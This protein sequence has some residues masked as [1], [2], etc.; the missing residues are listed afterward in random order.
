TTSSVS[1][2]AA[3]KYW[4]KL[5]DSLHCT[6]NSDTTNLKIDSLN[7]K[8]SLGADTTLCRN[9]LI[10]LKTPANGW[11]RLSFH[12]STGST[13]SIA[14]VTASG[15]YSVTVSDTTVCTASASKNINVLGS[16]APTV[17]FSGDTIC[18][19]QNY[20]PV[21]LTAPTD[22]VASYYW[23]F[24]DGGSSSATNAAHFYQNS[25]VYSASLRVITLA[26]CTTTVNKYV[27]VDALPTASFNGGA[28]CVDNSY[29][30]N[31]LSSPSSGSSLI[32]WNWDFGDGGLATTQNPQYTYATSGSYTAGLMVTDNYGCSG[33]TSHSITLTGPQVF[34]PVSLT[35][36]ANWETFGTNGVLFAWNP[37][38]GATSYTLQIATNPQFTNAQ[39]YPG[40]TICRDSVG[41]FAGNTQYYWRIVAYSTCG[42]SSSSTTGTFRTFKPSDIGSGCLA[43]WLA[44]DNVTLSGSTTNVST[45]L[46]TSGNAYHATATPG[47]PTWASEPQLNG[48]HVLHFSGT[49]QALKGPQIPGI[50][51]KSFSIFMVDKGDNVT[52]SPAYGQGLFTINTLNAGMWLYRR[53]YYADLT[54][55]NNYSSIPST[56][57]QW[58]NINGFANTGYPY[59]LMGLRKDFGNWAQLDTNGVVGAY[60]DN[61]SGLNSILLGAFTNGPYYIGYAS[62]FNQYFQGSI[63]ETIVYTCVLD[64]D[65]ANNVNNYLYTKYAPPVYLGPDTTETG[66]VCPVVLNAG[67]R[68][69]SYLWSTGATTQTISVQQNGTYWVRVKDVFNRES[70]DTINVTLP[71]LGSTPGDTAICYG[72]QVQIS[73]LFRGG[74]SYNYLWSNGATTSSIT[75][76]AAG[77]Y[78]CTVSN[79]GNASC[80]ILSDIVHVHVDSFALTNLLTT[81]TLL[82]TG[83]AVHLANTT[84]P[85]VSY[86]WSPSGDTSAAPLIYADGQYSL[87]VVDANGC[88]NTDT[89]NVTTHSHAPITD[90]SASGICLGNATAFTSLAAVPQPDAIDSFHWAFDGAIPATASTANPVVNFS[91]YGLHQVSLFVQTDSGCTGTITKIDTIYPTP[92]AGFAYSGSN[93]APSAAGVLCAGDNTFGI[94]SDSSLAIVAIDSI[95]SRVWE[96]DGVVVDSSNSSTII[97]Q[98][99]NPGNYTVSLIVTN[100]EGCTDSVSRPVRVFAPLNAD[101][102][103]QNVCYGQT[104]KFTDLTASY[105]LVS[106]SWTFGDNFTSTTQN[107]THRYTQPLSF[108]ATLTVQNAIGC[109]ANITK[110]V[111]IYKNPVAAFTDTIACVGDA[112]TPVDL[113]QTFGDPIQYWSW[114]IA[115]HTYTTQAP[116]YTFTDTGTY[117]IRL[118]ITT[119]NSCADSTSKHV[120]VAPIPV[121][122][123]TYS[124]LY[125]SA[126]LTITLTNNSTGANWYLWDFGD[127]STDSFNVN[128][129]Y[130]YQNNGDYTIVLYA[131][132]SYG[133]TDSFSRK[134]SVIATNLDL[135]V[136]RVWTYQTPQPNG[137]IFF[138]VVAQISNVQTRPITSAQLKATVGSSGVMIQD[139]TG[140]LLPGQTIIDTFPAQFDVAP[141]NANSYVCVEGFN[142]NNGETET[143][144]DNNQACASL[145]SSM[146]L[147]GPAPMPAV[148]QSTL[149]II[150]PAAG[151]VNIDIIDQLGQ[152][153]VNNESFT[154]PAGRS[155][156]E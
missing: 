81:D 140:Y 9:S 116:Q 141:A 129:N 149:G 102:Y 84:Y 32:S 2:V 18:Y 113:S 143:R 20:L 3:G 38:S 55:I 76:S 80:F 72:R 83:S 52:Q 139:W 48:H 68:F 85:I 147:V 36:P 154:L 74:S 121:A 41:G 101:F 86:L 122:N 4:V 118:K 105:S 127:G 1:P 151:T 110:T 103:F 112:Y 107:P 25:G 59:T 63:A 111:T 108:P 7:S 30:F 70:S 93:S 13:D 17:N 95:V 136:D 50:D 98:F 60:I 5:T 46:D 126:P 71:Y 142:V 131:R 106:W 109:I 22:S 14:V 152:V 12:W 128:T 120:Y 27:I 33:H 94:F 115:G 73:Q 8:I 56:N 19:L 100:N 6:L 58:L 54:F 78:S 146:Q 82:C 125:G 119:Q 49:S 62:N 90:F 153:I 51:T 16:L 29:Q 104:T 69:I 135:S 145:N 40:L 92:I 144:Y 28:G 134:Y 61:S 137:Y 133:C 65:Q 99:D 88:F 138:T 124:P 53:T 47:L 123:F 75:V 15:V 43:V 23:T 21:N 31:D 45:W 42:D 96:F 156:Y 117:T 89:I 26:G 11:N 44:G 132:N 64:S 79:T 57:T 91:A 150:L 66:S 34:Q 39:T 24:G 148:T 10:S 155:D 67:A 97:H 130:I 87:T 114:N 35:I 37:T 77:A